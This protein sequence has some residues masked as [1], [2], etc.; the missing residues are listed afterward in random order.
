MRNTITISPLRHAIALAALVC[1]LLVGFLPAVTTPALGLWLPWT[2]ERDKIQKIASD[3]WDALVKNDLTTVNA[4]VAGD[5]A[6]NFIKQ[7]I[8]LIKSL[9]IED[10]ECYVRNFQLDTV[11]GERALVVIEKV[12][13]QENGRQVKRMDMSVFRKI[14]GQ[15]KIVMEKRKGRRTLEDIEPLDEDMLPSPSPKA[16]DGKNSATGDSSAPSGPAI[17]IPSVK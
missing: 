4:Y 6:D 13:T 15:W 8:S 5:G 12:A 17:D 16:A 2:T 7:E 11:T 1:L 3:V 14:G 9:K 10:Y